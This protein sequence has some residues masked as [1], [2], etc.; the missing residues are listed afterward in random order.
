M[1]EILTI[2]VSIYILYGIGRDLLNA[3]FFPDKFNREH[4]ALDNEDDCH[5]DF[6]D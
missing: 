2:I 4:K 1:L 6:I 3:I 5:I